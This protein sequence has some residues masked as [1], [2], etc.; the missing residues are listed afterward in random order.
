[1]RLSVKISP[2]LEG[3]DLTFSPGEEQ[4]AKTATLST[5]GSGIGYS[6]E[7]EFFIL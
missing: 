3:V 4:R 2:T 6:T 5:Q 7:I 1:M